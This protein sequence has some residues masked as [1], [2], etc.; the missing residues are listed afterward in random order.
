V[1]GVTKLVLGVLLGV[2]LSG[3]SSLGAESEESDRPGARATADLAGATGTSVRVVAVGDIACPPNGTRTRTTCRQADTGRLA[4]SRHPDHVLAL[5]DLQYE[6][7][8]YYQFVHSYHESWGALKPITKALP[9]NHEYHTAGA[10][11]YY[12]YVG[13]AEPGY[14]AWN[15]GSWR[16]YNLNTNCGEVN[17][18]RELTWLEDDLAAH[19]RACSVIAM[20]HPRFS[21]GVEHG[22]SPEVRPFWRIAYRHRVDVALAGHDHDYE[23]FVRLTPSG[24]RD[25]EHGIRSFVSGA[26]GKSL[27]RVGTRKRG[28]VY[29]QGSRFGVLTLQLGTGSYRWG[30]RTVDGTLR[31]SGR[32]ACV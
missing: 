16:I 8:T 18:S 9:G 21:S 27:Y 10:A 1:A 30:F 11:G 22:N 6:N 24:A 7:A 31:D 26:G 17:C 32:S 4:A 29:F 19:P 15:A 25:P 3:C 13:G 14:Y 20:H 12:R 5:G 23:R 28:S 2:L